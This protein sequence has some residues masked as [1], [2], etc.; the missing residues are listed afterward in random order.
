[1]ND[2][3]TRHLLSPTPRPSAVMLRGEGSY[4]FDEDGRRYLDFVQG[5]AVNCHGHSPDAIR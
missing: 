1:M 2:D 3:P 5:W 4:L